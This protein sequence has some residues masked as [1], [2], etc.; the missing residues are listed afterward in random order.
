MSRS[1]SSEWQLPE[2]ARAASG[3]ARLLSVVFFGELRRPF[4]HSRVPERDLGRII[5]ILEEPGQDRRAVAGRINVE[6]VLHPATRIELVNRDLAIVA[7]VEREATLAKKL[8]VV[9]ILALPL[10]KR[11]SDHG[12]RLRREKTET[13]G[14]DINPQRCEIDQERIHCGPGIVA[15]H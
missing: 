11:L 7:D 8:R 3:N 1:R 5:L 15:L 13:I 4:V 14:K 9:V 2:A 6:V 10:E 12:R